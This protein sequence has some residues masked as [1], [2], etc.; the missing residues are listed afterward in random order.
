MIHGRSNLDI[1]DEL[2]GYVSGHYEAKKA[3]ISL[4]NRAK[5]RHHQKWIEGI[6]KDYLI[7]PHKLLL[8]G[9][10]GTGKTH[11][12][13]SLQDI[14]DFPLIRIDATKMNPTGAGGGIKE[15][16]LRRILSFNRRDY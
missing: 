4:V 16:D 15:E 2:D 13:E 12:V 3:L 10:S 1:L 8:I 11:L 6:H 7:Q 9:Q 5:I 14:L